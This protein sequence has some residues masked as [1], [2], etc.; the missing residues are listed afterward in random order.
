MVLISSSACPGTLPGL[1]LRL[2]PFAPV[3]GAL[4]VLV[5]LG[6]SW[7]SLSG[8]PVDQ[9]LLSEVQIPPVYLG[10]VVWQVLKVLP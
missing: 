5:L 7:S 2:G 9:Q 8:E 6:P 3:V 10:W 1:G 4:G